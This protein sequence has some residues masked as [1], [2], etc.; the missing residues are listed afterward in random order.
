MDTTT[1]DRR[2]LFIGGEWEKP[3][4]EATVEVI[5]AATETVLGTSA[6]GTAADIDAA[7]AAA[8]RALPAWRALS[9]TDRAEHLDRFAAALRS[10]A[11]ET[12]AL[13]SR[14]NGMPI[15]LSINVNGYAPSLM[16]SY[17]A[18]A[19]RGTE[20]DEVRPSAFG[21]RT[22]VRRDSVGV[23][24]AITPWNYPQSLAAMKLAPALAAGC[25]VVLKPAPETALDA[26]V[27]ADAA[28][29]AGLPPGVLN[30]VVGGREAGA[31]LVEHPG[32]DKVAFT[33]STAAG[34]AIGEVC[35]RLLRPVTLEL[36]GKSASI[37]AADADLEVFAAN[38]LEVSLVNNGQTCHAGTRILAPRSRY[39]EVVEVVTETVRG[40]RIGDPL[41]RAT[42]IGPL[43]SAAQRDRVLGFIESGRWD[44]YRITTGGGIPADLP[45]GWY[46]EP[47]VF[48]GVHNAARIAQEEIFGPVLTITP[49]DGEADAIEIAN[50]SRYGL[51]GT[52]WTTDEER[53]LAIADRIESGTVG[54]NH[55]QLDLDAPF[56]GVKDS[57]LGRELGPEGLA[58]YYT[59]KSVYFGTR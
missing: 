29:A 43:V 30:V 42:Q 44:G 8:R 6:S 3:Q 59:A 48:E 28:V 35:G 49:Y 31:H 54:V 16:M 47:T 56:G 55:Y 10:R 58:P 22:V 14:E 21:G 5:E 7:V 19:V 46:V 52:V 40:L 12:A 39:S 45:T 36:G 34:R 4:T 13:A 18:N 25:T 32:V 51:G 24:A 1:L 38:L 33:G 57:G 15:A 17:Y 50:D 9:S 2:A 11:K 26:Y 41:D 20:R 23:V 27:F 37:V 53:G